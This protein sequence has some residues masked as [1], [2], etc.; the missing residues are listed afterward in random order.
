MQS[1]LDLD[2]AAALITGETA[3]WQR[4]GLLADGLTWR[5][6][7]EPWPYPLKTKRADVIDGD[8]VGVAV[9]KG[10]RMGRLVLF[11][12]GWADLEYWSGRP[13]DEPLL[14][15]P[16]WDDWLTLADFQ[17]LLWRFAGLFS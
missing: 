5:D 11:R 12:G 6:V 15:A 9:H 8:S 7:G 1:H 4:T 3:A 17:R 16:G 13:Q 2:E 14:E 10:D